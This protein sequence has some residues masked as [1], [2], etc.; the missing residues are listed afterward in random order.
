MSRQ[1]VGDNPWLGQTFGGVHGKDETT[2]RRIIDSGYTKGVVV[3]KELPSAIDLSGDT[4]SSKPLS[5]TRLIQKDYFT[6]VF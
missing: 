4:A 1:D 2:A 3:F 5:R 6:G